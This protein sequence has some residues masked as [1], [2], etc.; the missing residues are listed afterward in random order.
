[1]SSGATAA[2]CT[3]LFIFLW[4]GGGVLVFFWG[5]EGV[6]FVWVFFFTPP[7]VIFPSSSQLLKKV[8]KFLDRYS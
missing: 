4:F 5:G 1:M 3:K 8:E 6:L 7:V 2:Q